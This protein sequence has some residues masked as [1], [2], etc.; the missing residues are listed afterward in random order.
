MEIKSVRFVCAAIL[1]GI[2]A[3]ATSATAANEDEL[4][5]DGSISV[6]IQHL[7]LDGDEAKFNEYRNVDD[8][9]NPVVENVMLRGYKGGYHFFAQGLDLDRDGDRSLKVESGHFGKFQVN[10]G[11]DETSHH[12]ADDAPFLGTLMGGGYWAMPDS[13]RSDL[14][15]EFPLGGDP[16]GEPTAAGV[17]LLTDLLEHANRLDLDLER[18]TGTVDLSFTPVK[19]LDL[20]FSYLHRDHKGLRPLST[21]LYRRDS[22]GAFDVGGVGENF[23]LYG[24]ELPEPIDYD[25]DEV[26][27]G[28]HYRGENW[29]ANLGYQYVKFENNTGTVSWDNPLRLTA[30]PAAAGIQNGS[31]KSLLDLFPSSDSH[32][33]S[34]TGGIWDLPL[35][36]R[37]T[38]T[39]SWGRI[40]QDDDF[41]AY[42]VND[43]LEASGGPG[44]GTLG[45]DLSL[46]AKDLDGQVDTLLINAVL[47]TRPIEPLS[48]NFK[49]NYYDYDDDSD[50]ISWVDGW[51]RIG[52]SEWSKDAEAGVFNRVTDWSR[53][54]PSVDAAYRVNEMLTVMGDYT[55]EGY[56]RNSDRNADTDEH[57]AGGRIKLAPTDWST[58]RV[59][60]QRSWRNIDVNYNNFP[61]APRGEFFEDDDL[62]MFDQADRKRD[63]VNAYL[64]LD[65]VDRLSLGFSFDYRNDDYDKESDDVASRDDPAAPDDFFGLHK[66][67]GY[68]LGVDASYAIS[69][70]VSVFAYYSRDD[71]DTKTLTRAKTSADGGG[72]FIIPENNWLTKITD[73]V[74][75]V[76]GTIEIDLIPEKLTLEIGGDYS[77]GESNY[78]SSNPNFEEGVTTS[79]ATAY[80]WSDTEIKTTQV[81]A[82][83][84]YHFTKNLSTSIR[85]L[86]EKYDLKDP[87]TDSVVPYG[88]P[89]D[90]QGNKLD[91]FI[92]MDAN[93]SDYKANLITWTV[94]YDF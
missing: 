14:Q 10:L 28:F 17:T 31:Q 21:G 61:D 74:D 73:S 71:Y 75:T 56:T 86:Y 42:T 43:T 13:V 68:M 15:A 82:E 8:E 7:N 48:L 63:R 78:N 11:W 23:M 45:K 33:V 70:R 59:G 69:D 53:I 39:A 47:S 32:K 89:D 94:S 67:E 46:A 6:G 92:F 3:I 24:L 83:L 72:S 90:M 52:E 18:K 16:P 22:D 60:Y 65:P 87:F 40:M 49:V 54:R 44:A 20:R 85:Y 64:S 93:Y 1:A 55:Y 19:D 26:G 88:N 12:F 5:I 36:S 76:G 37:F 84:D 50:R 79:S 62:R 66:R 38:V 9:L 30:W 2:F 41:P 4:D 58:L 77:F 80:D 25:T 35:D 51:A 91:Y 57:I 34:F 29:N 27:S 81:R